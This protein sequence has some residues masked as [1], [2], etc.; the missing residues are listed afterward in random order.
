M[1]SSVW[2]F[3]GISILVIVTPGPDTALTIRNTVIGGRP[4]GIFTALGVSAG[5]LVWALATSAGV[6]ALLLASEP[7]FHAVKLGGAAYLLYLGARSLLAA[8]RPPA[9]ASSMA[10]GAPRRRLGPRAAFRQ[11]LVNNLG[12]PK[13][14][15]FFAS[16]LPQFA[17]EG[18]GML[19]VLVLLGL[20]FSTLTLAWLALY[21]AAI[22][23]VGR[24]LQRSGL[25][26]AIE[27]LSG[28]VLMGLGARL[29]AESR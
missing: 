15:V 9:S 8:L 7:I 10:E 27:G 2:A 24:T 26:R 11:G 4:G 14:A 20:V 13:M 28:A 12:N 29:A 25:R 17:R 5:Q 6:V 3:L 18:E 1:D 16:V 23:A 22:A 19:S 21:A